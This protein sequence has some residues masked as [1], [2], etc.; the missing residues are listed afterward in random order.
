MSESLPP[1]AIGG[2]YS[3]LTPRGRSAVAVVQ[4]RAGVELFDRPPARFIAVNGRAQVVGRDDEPIP[5]LYAA[6]SCVGGLEGGPAAGYVGGLIKAFG[7][8]LIAA[9]AVATD[10]AA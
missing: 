10:R 1:T 2:S 4:I 7:I 9:D 3:V 6:G 5:G 8:G